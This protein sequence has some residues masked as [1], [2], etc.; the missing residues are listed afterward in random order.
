MLQYLVI[1]LDD[2]S[3]AYCHAE[4][5]LTEVNLIS[6][7]ML[8]QAIT[9]GM[10]H[11]LMIQFVLPPYQM[12]EE[13]YTLMDSIDNIKIGRDVIVCH[14]IPES[15]TTE[16]VVLCISIDEFIEN[17]FLVVNVLKQVKRLC[18]N[19]TDINKFSDD[20]IKKYE[21]SLQVVAGAII[22]EI[23]I[24]KRHEINLITDRL[25]LSKMCN[26]NAGVNNITIAPNG[27]FYLC[28]AFYYDEKN[29]IYTE[30]DYRTPHYDRSIGNLEAGLK[31]KNEQLLCLEN[32]PLC[33]ECD[34]YHCNRCVW[35]NQKMTYEIN[36][37]SHEQCVISHIERN[38]AKILSDKMR[39]LGF[40][41]Q[42]INEISYLDPFEKLFKD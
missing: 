27:K 17:V 6:L 42:I 24:G 15:V 2:T 37:P 36:T 30:I 16:T 12:P 3:V 23:C 38:A 29:E 25:N 7:D 21:S 34:A 8:H 32:S 13:Y 26:C 19:Y 40:E 20:K 35:L 28:P 39:D 11:N 22:D 10:K 41:T 5:P 14:C 4:N 18:I 33:N 31:N 1:L 9:Y